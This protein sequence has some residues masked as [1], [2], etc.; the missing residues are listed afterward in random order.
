M[1]YFINIHFRFLTILIS[2]F[3]SEKRPG[4]SDLIVL[5]A[6]ND[7]PTGIESSILYNFKYFNNS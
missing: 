7:D 2:Y 5:V 1:Y 4:R 3:Y 6:H